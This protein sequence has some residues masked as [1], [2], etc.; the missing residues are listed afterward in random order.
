MLPFTTDPSPV[1][2][3]PMWALES[4]TGVIVGLVF[5]F[6]ALPVRWVFL[7]VQNRRQSNVAAFREARRALRDVQLSLRFEEPDPFDMDAVEADEDAPARDERQLRLWDEAEA[8][9]DLAPG[10]KMP[11]H[12]STLADLFRRSGVVDAMFPHAGL[13]PEFAIT[14]AAIAVLTFRIKHRWKKLDLQP[15][16][17]AGWRSTI[18]GAE[19]EWDE[20]DRLMRE[21]WIE[22][23]RRKDEGAEQ[24]QQD[25]AEGRAE[26]EKG[27]PPAGA[28]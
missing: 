17:V 18:E 24:E 7:Y 11:E 25:A 14:D 1:T 6:L 21:D 22:W 27:T 12:I 13:N 9:L 28:L 3:V 20:R 4:A 26:Y 2:E 15:E 16:E 19:H 23:R 5:G 8:A 10:K